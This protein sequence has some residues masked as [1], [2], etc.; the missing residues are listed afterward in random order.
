MACAGGAG[1]LGYDGGWDAPL[2]FGKGD[3]NDIVRHLV[4]RADAPHRIGSIGA[5]NGSAVRAGAAAT[6][7]VA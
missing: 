6:T 2:M 7:K 3:D 1:R 5:A 4:G